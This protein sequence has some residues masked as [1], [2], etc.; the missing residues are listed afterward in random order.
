VGHTNPEAEKTVLGCPCSAETTEGTAAWRAGMLTATVQATE[1]PLPEPVEAMLR[2]LAAGQGEVPDP[3]NLLMALQLR[4][5]VQTRDEVLAV[6]D[7]GRAYLAAR[8]GERKTVRAAVI[9]VDQADRTAR[10]ALRWCRPD[11]HVTVCLERL[12]EATGLQPA[13]LVGTHLDVTANVYADRSAEIVL[14]D[15]TV[16]PAPLPESWKAPTTVEEASDA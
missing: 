4:K 3:H 5:F 14:T 10:V 6:T 12:V 9:H 2:A 15:L 1:L 8:D 13:E 7:F 16:P 11:H